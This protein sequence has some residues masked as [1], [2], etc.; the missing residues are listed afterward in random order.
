MS[1]TP[2]PSGGNTG[3]RPPQA[4]ANA[5]KQQAGDAAQNLKDQVQETAGTAVDQVKETATTQIGSQKDRVTANL[6]G[7]ADSLHNTGQQLENAKQGDFFAKYVHQVADRVDQ[8]ANRLDER[9]V[10]ELIGDVE[11][12]ARKQPA[13]FLGGTFVLG[14]LVARFLKSSSQ[15][16]SG[17]TSAPYTPASR[18]A[19]AYRPSGMNAAPRPSSRPP[20]LPAPSTSG[21]AS[22]AGTSGAGR[23]TGASPSGNMGATPSTGTTASTG[24]AG[25]TGGMSPTSTPS[26]TPM[27]SSPTGTS[28]TGTPRVEDADRLDA[29]R[30]GDV[31]HQAGTTGAAGASGATSPAGQSTRPTTGDTTR[32]RETT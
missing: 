5:V 18:G 8:L 11:S 28:G 6:S 7:L 12:Y 20:S 25:R 26:A 3:N 14:M 23:M 29:L 17:E 13:V 27:T 19:G 15:S 31:P 10:N 22:A 4:D 2:R 30:R 32:N 24:A 1:T 9:D 21:A 16:E